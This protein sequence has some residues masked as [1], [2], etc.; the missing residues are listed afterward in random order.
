[1]NAEKKGKGGTL[2]FLA[3]IL[4]QNIETNERC[5]LRVLNLPQVVEQMN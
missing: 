3:S 2:G 1:M 5:T 4:L